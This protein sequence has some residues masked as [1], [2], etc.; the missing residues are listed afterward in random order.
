M[1]VAHTMPRLSPLFVQLQTLIIQ[2]MVDSIWPPGKWS[3]SE[4]SLVKKTYVSEG[5][6]R[7]TLDA[8]VRENLLVRHQGRDPFISSHSDLRELFRLFH[9]F[10][11]SDTAQ[12]PQTSHLIP[13]QMRKC[14]PKESK[15]LKISEAVHVL[16]IRRVINMGETPVFIENIIVPDALITGLGQQYIFRQ[17]IYLSK[18]A[19][20]YLR[21]T[22]LP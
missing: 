8:L 7:K 12:S 21:L 6:V 18:K 4:C 10:K 15:R 19:T 5:I 1:Q 3:P 2:H 13:H 14:L 17:H 20:P 16:N 11:K 22:G 9:L